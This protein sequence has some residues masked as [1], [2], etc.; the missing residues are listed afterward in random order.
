MYELLTSGPDHRLCRLT[1]GRIEL[2]EEVPV[3]A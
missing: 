1:L 2:I 3:I